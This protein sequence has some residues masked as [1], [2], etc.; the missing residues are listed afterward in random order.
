MKKDT[1]ILD[2]KALMPRMTRIRGCF[3]PETRLWRD[4]KANI[5][6][7]T[8]V[9]W[10][11]IVEKFRFAEMI[12]PESLKSGS[13]IDHMRLKGLYAFLQM[14]YIIID[15]GRVAV[16]NRHKHH[17]TTGY[18]PFVTTS[19]LMLRDHSAAEKKLKE[20]IGPLVSIA[21]IRPF[22][23][24]YT[25]LEAD[26]EH[27]SPAYLWILHKVK[28]NQEL[29]SRCSPNPDHDSFVGMKNISSLR[30]GR[31][32]V[33]N[34]SVE[35]NRNF[36]AILLDLLSSAGSC[37]SQFKIPDSAIRVLTADEINSIPITKLRVCREHLRRRIQLLEIAIAAGV[38]VDW[39]QR[40]DWVNSHIEHLG[41]YLQRLQHIVQSW[42]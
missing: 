23:I 12:A 40:S 36:D 35:V 1:F 29:P 10:V 2:R 16:F 34:R 8:P 9:D 30:R 42:Y 38:T 6:E 31:I 11:R 18:S 21:D 13:R 17:I 24:G 7:Q 28:L 27:S 15:D 19:A 26:A 20:Q 32:R 5:I 41:D 4:I 39:C 14:G 37:K 25:E 3:H 33:L 22:A